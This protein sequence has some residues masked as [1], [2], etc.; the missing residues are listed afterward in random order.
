MPSSHA[1]ISSRLRFLRCIFW[2]S[3]ILRIFQRAAHRSD[4][5]AVDGRLQRV[6]FLPADVVAVLTIADT[7]STEKE[8]GRQRASK[9]EIIA[10]MRLPM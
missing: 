2:A 1:P 10:C 5:V 9:I 4:S 8:D 3:G 7:D 6:V